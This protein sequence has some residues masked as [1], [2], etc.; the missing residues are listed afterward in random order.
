MIKKELRKVAVE[1]SFW[2]LIAKIIEK[3][4]SLVFT[5]VLARF[6]LP[7][8][9]GAYNLVMAVAL[10]FIGFIN[11]AVD[12]TLIRYVS[13]ALGGKNKKLASD[14]FKYILKKKIIFA[15]ISAVLILIFAYPLSFYVFKKPFLFLPLFVSG[16]YILILGIQN[17]YE[18]LFYVFKELKKRTIKEILKQT[19]K[20]LIIIL[21]FLF[22]AKSYYVVGA[23]FGLILTNSIIFIFI[24]WYIKRFAGFIFKGKGEE[25]FN[26]KRTMKFLYYLLI[27][28]GTGV[29]FSYVDVFMLGVFL[30]EIE[31]LGFYS[32][33]VALVWGVMGFLEFGGVFLP[34]FSQL[35]RIKL[36]DAFNQVMKYSFM[37]SIP[38]AFG[39][40]ALSKYIIFLIYGRDYLEASI[41]LSLM[42]FL[43]I[44]GT[45]ISFINTLFSAREKPKYTA[46]MGVYALVLNV[47]LNFIFI[48]LLLNISQL[49]AIIGAGIATIISRYSFT[50][51]MIIIMKKKLK[52]RLKSTNWIKPLLASS[53]MLIS[54]VGLNKLFI[55]D[56]SLIS[57]IIEVIMGIVVYFVSLYLIKGFS[58]EDINLIKEVFFNNVYKSVN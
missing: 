42:A 40:A 49:W 53:I 9:F 48:N 56:M 47:I 57:G 17:S 33:A 43:I 4:G 10:T 35:K 25:N 23:I 3:L 24:I 11:Y 39:I 54:L 34:I 16:F 31:Y 8:G 20:I 1:N 38:A 52:I 32:A 44:E 51:T 50:I 5:I 21:V 37:I 46:K 7:E 26:K 19:L 18:S 58:R 28:G 27:G 36:G 13:N 6:L 2:E 22:V 14:Y 41:V 55:I 30:Q 12:G 29:V 15:V 45:I